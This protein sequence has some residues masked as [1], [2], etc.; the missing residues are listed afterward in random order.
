[1]VTHGEVLAHDRFT[2]PHHVC[3]RREPPN[4]WDRN[5]VAVEWT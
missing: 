3:L 1:M 4:R 5:A 2:T